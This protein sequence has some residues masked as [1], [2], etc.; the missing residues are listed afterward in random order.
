MTNGF[1][2][3]M[4]Q[5]PEAWNCHRIHGLLFEAKLGAEPS[6]NQTTVRFVDFQACHTS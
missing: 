5:T 4:V 6:S 2:R 3:K 1:N